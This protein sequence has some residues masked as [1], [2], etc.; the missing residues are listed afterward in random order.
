MSV[1]VQSQQQEQIA[2][3]RLVMS[4][5]FMFIA[6]FTLVFVFL[7]IA[8]GLLIGTVLGPAQLTDALIFIGGILLVVM[9]IHM[10][11]VE[12]WLVSKLDA[13]P[14]VQ[15]PLA[16]IDRK[17]DEFILPERRKQAGYGQSPGYVRSS[18]VGMA[19]AAGWTPC[20]GPLLG[21][22]LTIAASSAS[23]NNVTG[24]VIQSTVLLFAYSLGLALPFLLVAWLLN[25]ATGLLSYLKKHVHI[26]E[27]ISAILII[28]VGVLLL[29]GSI[30]ELNRYF[31]E[32]PEWAYQLELGLNSYGISVPIAFLAGTLSFLSPCVL[33]LIP[34]YIGYLTGV[35]AV[36]SSNVSAA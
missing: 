18:I 6:G 5:A 25:K 14:M 27:K 29:F 13:V 3:R 32:Q 2:T 17:V 15:K 35:A 10:L 33:P 20:I 7:G 21:A 23:A 12:K 16:K 24:A 4:H 30:S 22:I 28:G 36:S 8:T 31:A 19:F 1:A 9:G 11:G 26:V 34:V